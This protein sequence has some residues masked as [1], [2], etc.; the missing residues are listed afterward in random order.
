M[1]KDILILEGAFELYA[2][3]EAHIDHDE[4]EYKQGTIK[5]HFVEWDIQR[6]Y[7]INGDGD[8]ENITLPEAAQEFAEDWIKSNG[9]VPMVDEIKDAEFDPYEYEQQREG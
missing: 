9:E 2:E 1:Q 5:K 3:I 4:Y 6:F 7:F 8:K